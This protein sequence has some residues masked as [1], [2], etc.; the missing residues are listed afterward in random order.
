M[1]IRSRHSIFLLLLLLAACRKDPETVFNDEYTL[2]IPAGFPEP[3]F[4]ADNALTRTRVELGRLLFFDPVLSRDSSISCGSCHL[5][6]LAFSDNKALSLGIENRVG[7]RNAPSLANVAY[8]PVFIRDGGVPTLELQVL[9]P[10][11]DHLEMDF[12]IVEAGQRLNRNERYIRLSR[13]AYNRDPDPYVILR[14][15]AAFQRTFI[16]GNS[17]YDKYLHAGGTLSTQEL[18]GRDLF[19]SDSLACSHCH[20]GFNFTGNAFENNGLYLTYSDSGRARITMRAED[21][22]K[23]RVPSLRNIALTAP[24]MHD[25][26]L[27]SLSEVIDHYASGGTTHANKN[28]IIRPFS[29]PTDDK[30]ALILFLESLTDNEFVHNP[31][32]RPQ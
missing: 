24:Y 23:F 10:I 14:A 16:S 29:L 9:V 6:H 17:R 15:L 4:P 20:S 27:V 11:D 32:F 19:F 5:P 13:R 3:S 26:S 12:N 18:R 25:G 1:R 2:R 28:P 8:L 30:Q 31:S 7:E 21:N 22:G